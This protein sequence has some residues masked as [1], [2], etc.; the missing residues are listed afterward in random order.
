M[1]VPH[2]SARPTIWPVTVALGLTLVLGSV[3]TS[4]VVG[5]GGAVLFALGLWGWVR[6]LLGEASPSA[7]SQERPIP[8]ADV[9]SPDRPGDAQPGKHA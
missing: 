5:I 2:G 3:P 6:D 4:A 9:P 1:G 7:I 8:E